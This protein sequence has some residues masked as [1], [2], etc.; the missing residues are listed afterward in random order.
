VG[1]GG[2]QDRPARLGERVGVARRAQEAVTVTAARARFAVFDTAAWLLSLANIA[3]W[4]V[5]RL[6]N[7]ASGR[8]AARRW[9]S[10]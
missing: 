5:A 2:H 10:R 9:R 3:A 7:R 6:A 4:N 1:V 8:M